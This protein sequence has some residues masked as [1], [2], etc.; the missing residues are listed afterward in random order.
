MEYQEHRFRA[1]DDLE[2]YYR[3]YGDATAAKTPV[4]CLPGLTRNS[5]DFHEL[6]LHLCQ[7]RRVICPDPRG[8]GKSARPGRW[9]HQPASYAPGEPFLWGLPFSSTQE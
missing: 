9:L 6:A 5:I 4:L 1:Q 7:D 3:D 8:R 2:L